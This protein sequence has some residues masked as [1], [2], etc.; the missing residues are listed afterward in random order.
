[1]LRHTCLLALFTLLTSSPVLHAADSPREKLLFDLNWKFRNGDPET[2]G[3]IFDY[4]ES[5]LSKQNDK[6]EAKESELAKNRPDEVKT[7]LG[8]NV[9]WVQPD[10]DDSKWR[11][12]NLPHD[13]AIEMPFNE[14]AKTGKGSKQLSDKD[15]T[16]IG[17]YRRTFEIPVQDK[18]RTLWIE[19]GG[20]Y[21]NTL[22]WLNGHCLGRTTSG[23]TPFYFDVTKLVNYGGKNTLVARLEAQKDEGWFY[24]GAGIYRHVWLIKTRDVHVAHWGTYVTS[25]VSGD[26]ATVAIETTVENSAAQPADAKLISIIQDSAGA[27]VAQKESRVQIDACGQFVARQEVSVPHPKLWSP[28]TPEMYALITRIESAGGLSDL[29][30]TPFGIRTVQF[31]ADKG[32]LLNGKWR[33]IKGVC[34]HQD[35]AGVGA[36][37]PDRVQEYRVAMLKEMGC[38]G[39]RTSHNPVNEELLDECDRQGMMVMDETRRFGKYSEPLSDL[40]AM[41]LRDRN[42]P[43]VVIWSLGNEEMGLQGTAYGA[44]ACKVMQDLA[45]QLDPSRICTLAI[46]HSFDN[47][48]FT[49]VLDVTGMNYLKLWGSMSRFHDSHPDRCYIT[50]EEASTLTTRGLYFENKPKGYLTAYDTYVPGWGSTAEGWWNYYQSRPWVA[51]AFVWTGYDYRGEPTPYG[52]PCIGS[53]FGIMDTCGF[54]KDNYYY[55]KAWWTNEPVLHVYPH[56]NWNQVGH[57]MIHVKVTSPLAAGLQFSV[58][59]AVK[60]GKDGQEWQLY[61]NGDVHAVTVYI[62]KVTKEEDPKNPG[63]KKDKVTDVVKQEILAIDS[64]TNT[65][66]VP[67][68]PEY[69]GDVQGLSVSVSKDESPIHVWVQ[70][71][72]EEAEL[73]VNGVSKGRQKVIPLHHLEWTASYAPGNISV[74]GYKGG[75]AVKTEKIETTGPASTL[76]V[77]ANRLSIHGDGEDVAMVKVEALDDKGRFVPTANNV[78]HFEVKGGGKLLGVGNGDPSCHESDLGPDRSLFNGLAL[79]LVQASRESGS[80]TVTVSGQGLSSQSI[81]LPVDATM[82]RPV[83]P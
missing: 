68:K 69:A 19:F 29:C 60:D 83:V 57:R 30:R 3:K 8:G 33:F 66:L 32:F 25:T 27:V 49:T 65:G 23:Y 34:N 28:E 18:G 76:R 74:T 9:A 56:W 75:Q 1:M 12:V 17:W 36:A 22:V 77:T 55:Y 40:K 38:D 45:H 15:G 79:G 59:D 24:E 62:R 26:A 14:H 53:H 63:K 10:F 71:N 64:G 73:F 47:E 78:I 51:G 54:P 52:W 13:W 44:E 31:T 21:R 61:D 67:L 4:P 7:N 5:E 43:S 41:M 72:Y 37:V 2:A 70:T 80:L 35:F 81:T 39:W 42:H 82:P 58:V 50:S 11:V 48:G 46:N 16:G 20:A 6:S